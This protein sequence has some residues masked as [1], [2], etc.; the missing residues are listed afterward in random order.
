MRPERGAD[1]AA[2]SGFSRRFPSLPPVAEAAE[3]LSGM[4][5]VVDEL[6]ERGGCDVAGN[7]YRRGMALDPDLAHLKAGLL[8]G[9]RVDL[10][11]DHGQDAFE[12]HQLLAIRFHRVARLNAPDETEKRGWM[13]YFGEHF[14]HGDEHAE[15][16]WVRWRI[17]LVKDEYPG[18]GVAISHDQ[19]HAHWK[20]VEP[21]GLFINLESM[22]DDFEKSVESFIAMLG[23]EPQRR[24]A[25]LEYWATRQ[26]SVQGVA[27]APAVA[28]AS[29]ATSMTVASASGANL[30]QPPTAR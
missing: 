12:R 16:L 28:T 14:P 5:N 19:P 11:P 15:L 10:A 22:W 1:S 25:A 7:R 8:R 20:M 18:P 26:Y 9:L 17:A 13:R 23:R 21:G 27:F 24:V 29:L 4:R 2:R 6:V 30:T 3:A